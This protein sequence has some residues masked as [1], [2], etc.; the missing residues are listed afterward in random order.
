MVNRLVDNGQLMITGWSS[1]V[2]NDESAAKKGRSEILIC[3]SGVMEEI[4]DYR[5]TICK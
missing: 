3:V 4:A 2:N 5:A 1:L